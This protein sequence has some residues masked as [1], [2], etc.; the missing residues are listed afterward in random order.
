[1]NSSSSVQLF[2]CTLIDFGNLLRREPD[3]FSVFEN[4]NR[5]SG[6]LVFEQ[7]LPDGAAENFPNRFPMLDE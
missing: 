3:D 5:I 7:C 4:G 1:V 6:A 2:S